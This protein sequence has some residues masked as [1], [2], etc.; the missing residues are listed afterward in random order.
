[1]AELAITSIIMIG[2]A[3]AAFYG[4]PMR[5]TWFNFGIAT[6]IFLKSV[7]NAIGA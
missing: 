7:I 1:M 3:L 5:I 6:S 4:G 2:A